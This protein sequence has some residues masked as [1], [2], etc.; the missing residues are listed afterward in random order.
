MPKNDSILIEKIIQVI[1]LAS[2]AYYSESSNQSKKLG[3]P[4]KSFTI[5]L[6]FWRFSRVTKK[7]R[8]RLKVIVRTSNY[9]FLYILAWKK[10]NIK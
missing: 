1:N 5:A 2:D 4:N 6:R 8:V 7:A 9:T 3:R 10:I